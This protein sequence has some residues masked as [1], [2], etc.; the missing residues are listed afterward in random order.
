MNTEINKVSLAIQEIV[1]YTNVNQSIVDLGM[2]EDA[3]GLGEFG[4]AAAMGIGGLLGALLPSFVY[5]YFM[6]MGQQI[7]AAAIT[8]AI[9]NFCEE[10]GIDYLDGL[11]QLLLA[12]HCQAYLAW[13]R[14]F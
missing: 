1:K 11:L 14:A 3:K 5:D 12:V 6:E 8:E 10:L 4:D 13:S 9:S 2:K 7:G